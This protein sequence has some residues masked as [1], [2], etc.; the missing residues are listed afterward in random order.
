MAKKS[1]I[2][3][4]REKN[5][6]NQNRRNPAL[7]TW[8]QRSCPKANIVPCWRRRSRRMSIVRS[9]TTSETSTA[10]MFALLLSV[11]G[12]AQTP[13]AGAHA[14]WIWRKLV[15]R[16]PKAPRRVNVNTYLCYICTKTR[17]HEVFDSLTN[18]VGAGLTYCGFGMQHWCSMHILQS[19]SQFYPNSRWRFY[20][21]TIAHEYPLCGRR[22]AP[23][24]H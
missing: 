13:C 6:S 2:R 20:E 5:I 24:K 19:P 11:F 8:F 22:F 18:G 16:L 14:E 10:M 17:V 7:P 3:P 23:R 9:K 12:T 21:A 15:R 1:Q 4:L